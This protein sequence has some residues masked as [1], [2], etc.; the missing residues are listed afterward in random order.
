MLHFST[1]WGN[2]CSVSDV[3]TGDCKHL[4]WFCVNIHQLTQTCFICGCL[5]VCVLHLLTC[6]S[7]NSSVSGQRGHQGEGAA[8][9]RPALLA[10]APAAQRR[11]HGVRDQI[12]REGE[13]TPGV[14]V[15]FLLFP[16]QLHH[17]CPIFIFIS[18]CMLRR[19]EPARTVFV[20]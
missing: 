8:A 11:H 13:S 5:C 12:L 3:W 14:F 17:I 15:L 6:S 18:S 1:G 19:T 16:P 20:S 2:I 4:E 10:G 7:P 9:Q